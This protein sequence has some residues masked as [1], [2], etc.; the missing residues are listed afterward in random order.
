M[1]TESPSRTLKCTNCGAEIP[2]D[3]RESHPVCDF[4]G[5]PYVVAPKSPGNALDQIAPCRMNEQK[6]RE[7]AKQFIACAQTDVPEDLGKRA[8]ITSCTGTYFPFYLFT[9]VYSGWRGTGNI[10]GGF[11]E[12]VPGSTQLA[13][14]KMQAPAFR[15]FAP[16]REV[17][18]EDLSQRMMAELFEDRRAM[19]HV[20]FCRSVIRSTSTTPLVPYT[21]T[22]DDDLPVG[23]FT[24][25]IDQA[26]ARLKGILAERAKIK[27][28]FFSQLDKKRVLWPFYVIEYSYIGIKYL[29][30]M[31]A[32][33]DGSHIGG[34]KPVTPER[35]KLN[36]TKVF[37]EDPGEV[38]RFF[39]TADQELTETM[40]GANKLK[41][42]SGKKLWQDDEDKASLK[43]GCFIA[44]AAYG[45]DLDPEVETLRRFRDNVLLKSAL[46]RGFVHLYYRISPPL[47]EWIAEGECRRALA[48]GIIKPIA[49]WCRHSKSL[50]E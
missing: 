3:A 27:D 49:R 35:A 31:D 28:V 30:F 41:L 13:A 37:D 1:E 33:G 10:S 14:T 20:E 26:E 43:I 18:L 40:S 45:S 8:R 46:G 50:H 12:L 19:V 16:K 38:I 42:F 36:F 47:A 6:A 9:G 48:R 25:P 29:V 2:F 11:T 21:N 17:T 22:A 24:E 23:G 32:A 44:T 15:F 5:S 4:C 39:E 7:T 34:Y